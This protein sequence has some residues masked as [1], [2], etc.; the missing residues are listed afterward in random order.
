MKEIKNIIICIVFSIC[1]IS[2]GVTKET[3]YN[4]MADITWRNNNGEEIKSW[5][6]AFISYRIKTEYRSGAYNFKD[7][8]TEFG[9]NNTDVLI[10]YDN[11]GNK[12]ALRYGL[13]EISNIREEIVT[14]KEYRK[15]YEE[16][17][18]Y[19]KM[20]AS[21]KFVSDE[22]GICYQYGNER[23]FLGTNYN[24]AYQ[25]LIEW[26]NDGIVGQEVVNMFV[27]IQ[28]KK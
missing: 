5:D 7:K 23:V 19:K 26:R 11:K 9:L 28:K 16:E 22:D 2:C 17:P 27:Q 3:I 6:N 25:T 14:T 21:G 18:S 1:A 24:E 10:F 20:D 13:W 8:I 12:C 4:T 15:E